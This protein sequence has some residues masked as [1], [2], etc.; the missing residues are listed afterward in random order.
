MNKRKKENFYTE[1]YNDALYKKKEKNK[2]NKTVG[3]H[4]YF[5]KLIVL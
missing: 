5:I 2:I 4:Q 3:V 1:K